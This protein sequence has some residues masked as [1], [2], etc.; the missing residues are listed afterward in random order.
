MNA[1]FGRAAAIGLLLAGNACRQR[2]TAESAA[3]PPSETTPPAHAAATAEVPDY[4][5]RLAEKAAVAAFLRAHPDLRPAADDD[6]RRSEASD[7]VA[8]LYGV[9]HPYFVR[10]DVN[11][12][13]LLDFVLAFVRRDSDRDVPWFSVAVFAGEAGGDLRAGSL[14]GARH[15]ALRRGPLRRP[16]RHR[17]DAGHGRRRDAALPV[18]PRA[19]PARVRPRLPGR[20]ALAAGGADLIATPRRI[21][22]AL[23]LPLRQS[24]TYL[25]PRRAARSGAGRAGARALRRAGAHRR[26][27]GRRA[28]RGVR[29][30]ARR[31]R[32]PRCRAG[33]PA[34]APGDG[35]PRGRALLRLDRRGPEERASGAGCPPPA[36][37]AIASRT[38]ARSPRLRSRRRSGRSWSSS[39]RANRSASWSF[40]EK[41]APGVRRFAASRRAVASVPWRRPGGAPGDSRRPGPPRHSTRRAAPGPSPAAGAAGRSSSSWRRSAAPPPPTRSGSRP[42]RARRC[43]RAS[44]RGA[45]SGPSS[46]SRARTARRPVRGPARAPSP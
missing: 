4:A 17:R 39:R 2:Q 45:S 1:R 46:R 26:H 16:R 43:S 40:P 25:D 24:F 23:P 44:L 20:A 36:P 28:A 33:L 9:Y 18:G 30:R 8:G 32:S 38:R 21:S 37:S 14:P 29:R 7:E 27:A 12:D 34:G 3:A 31:A 6:R 10:G 11:D 15:L 13:G 41:A 35:R 5:F 22:V 42:A 19:P